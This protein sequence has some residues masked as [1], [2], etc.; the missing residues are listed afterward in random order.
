GGEVFDGGVAW[1]EAPAPATRPSATTSASVPATPSEAP[2]SSERFF[3]DL[4]MRQTSFVGTCPLVG[5]T[6][7]ALLRARGAPRFTHT[8]RSFC[9]EVA[10][11]RTFA[12]TATLGRKLH[13]NSGAGRPR[14]AADEQVSEAG[15]RSRRNR[16]LRRADRVLPRLLP[17]RGAAERPGRR[18][19][20]AGECDAPDGRLPR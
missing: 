7:P 12:M 4:D 3:A 18:S 15:R 19:G 13:R 1:P 17:D 14:G 20:A 5:L 2:I 8:S 6:P 10:S 9:H 11:V 16:L